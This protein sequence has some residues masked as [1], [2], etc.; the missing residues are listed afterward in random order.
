[1]ATGGG[2]IV[3]LKD[4]VSR[5]A[6]ITRRDVDATHNWT[7]IN[8]FAEL[9][10]AL[11]VEIIR[12][13]FEAW[14]DLDVFPIVKWVEKNYVLYDRGGLDWARSKKLDYPGPRRGRD[15]KRSLA[16]MPSPRKIADRDPSEALQANSYVLTSKARAD[17]L[18]Q[19]SS[20]PS[21]PSTQSASDQADGFM[22]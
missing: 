8:G 1:M 9:S 16:G 5:S 21:S 18:F 19:I 20:P 4:G 22:P 12:R 10:A 2:Y 15:A 6:F 13:H 3:K 14:G 17:Q 7:I 11:R